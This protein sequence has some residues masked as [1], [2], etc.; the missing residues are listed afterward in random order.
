MKMPSSPKTRWRN[1]NKVKLVSSAEM[2]TQATHRMDATYYIGKDFLTAVLD[3]VTNSSKPTI[4]EFLENIDF[5]LDHPA[6]INQAKKN[7][8]A[9][10][11]E[12]KLQV[13]Q[14]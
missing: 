6:L 12:T 1:F 5:M 14:P 13:K 10:Q 4:H 7:W 9:A 11:K 2:A 8:E 3:E